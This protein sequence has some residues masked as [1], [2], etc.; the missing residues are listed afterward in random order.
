VNGQLSDAIPKLTVA[1]EADVPAVVSLIN[2][3]FR[4]RG[5]NT[6]WSTKEEY[7]EG[8]RIT[9]DLL[10][11]DIAAKPHATLLLWRGAGSELLGCVWMEPEHDG[12]WYLGLLAIPPRQQKAKLGRRLLQAAE[13]W[14]QERGASEIKMSVVNVR[15]A[16]ID[17][18]KRRGY[19]L[20]AETKPFP[21]GDTRFGKPQRDDLYFVVLRKRV[22]GKTNVAPT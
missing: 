16:L 2:L 10:R 17:W 4:G 22:T 14:A 20:T 19:F 12:V 21:Y 3:A 6:G 9:E 13:D 5:E 18:Y 11:E 15:A 7:I 1:T 8:T